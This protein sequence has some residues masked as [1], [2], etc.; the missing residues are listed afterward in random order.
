MGHFL[1]IRPPKKTGTII[2][3]HLAQARINQSIKWTECT[4]M[5]KLWKFGSCRLC[6]LEHFLVV[7]WTPTI[8]RSLCTRK[9]FI[10]DL[11]WFITGYMTRGE[12]FDSCLVVSQICFL[13]KYYIQRFS[14]CV[15]IVKKYLSDNK[16]F[17]VCVYIYVITYIKN[18]V[19]L[20]K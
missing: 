4:S 3:H 7:S 9:A 17:Y 1:Q 13:T 19:L 15:F 18:Y 20:N 5:N 6:S 8:T 14:Q 2:F 10:C 16:I 11:I 12:L